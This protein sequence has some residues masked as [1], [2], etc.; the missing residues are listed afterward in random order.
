M[1]MGKREP[2]EEIIDGE[3]DT[4]LLAC[5]TNKKEVLEQL[6]KVIPDYA[7]LAKPDN[8][9]PSKIREMHERIAN[10][11]NRFYWNA[12][13]E[14]QKEKKDYQR[15]KDPLINEIE[16]DAIKEA[17]ILMGVE[18]YPILDGYNEKL[19]KTWGEFIL[20]STKISQIAE[21]KKVKVKPL[22]DYLNPDISSVHIKTGALDTV[23]G[24]PL[25][26]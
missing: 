23:R 24:P 18:K 9:D 19:H 14:Y 10:L 6:F 11:F 2:L 5:E 21:E 12:F 13:D 22:S 8:F 17:I 20:I 1:I 26:V 4:L 25:Y 15:S 16:N 7:Q 3:S